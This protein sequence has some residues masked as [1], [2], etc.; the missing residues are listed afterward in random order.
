M[1]PSNKNYFHDCLPK[2]IDVTLE[3]GRIN[4]NK[5]QRI[6]NKIRLIDG[7]PPVHINSH[8]IILIRKAIE[9][10]IT[11]AAINNGLSFKN[12][13]KLVLIN[14]AGIAGL[15][16]SFELLARGFNV[17]IAEKRKSFDRFNV[18]N[19][20]V[21][22]Q[23]FLKKFGLL[24]EFEKS[25]AGRI[26]MHKY[27]LFEEKGI[28]NLG[29]SD[30]SKLLP[31]E[32]LFEPE[33]FNKL[34]NEDGIYSVRIKD[35]Q[36]FLSKKA[37]DAGVHIFGNIETE[38]LTCSHAGGVSKVKLRGIDSFSNSLEM[39]PHLLFLAEGAHSTTAK[40]LGMKNTEVKNECTGENWIFGS[41][42]YV[43]KET[44]VVSVIDT[45]G[46]SLE[47]ANII[48]N[49]Q[50]SE[51]N[52][53]VTSK[54]NLSQELM[55]QRLLKL[56]GRVC[57]H[58]NLEERQESLIALVKRPVHI[59]NEKRVIYSQD[60]VFCI[61]D[62]AG[63]SSPLAGM[64][65]TLGLT[66]VPRTIEQLVKDYEQQPDKAHYNFHRFTD[67]YTARWIAKSQAVKNYC[68][69]FFEAKGH[70]SNDQVPMP[71]KESKLVLKDRAST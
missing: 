11:A 62:A 39:Q 16:A 41:V 42:N 47:I 34:F 44:F 29:S 36:T 9:F 23:R 37:L 65:G 53:A 43:G 54:R 27:L 8:G 52:I 22:S 6:I 7:Q 51:I 66:L 60:N 25:V 32:V 57:V 30:V 12:S 31:S 4:K 35:L 64:G 48:F 40:Q 20:D 38:V 3:D 14:G 58:L 19:L 55:K 24:N 61:G 21:E 50:I 1:R 71:N 28:Q 56:V 13:K 68:L 5:I 59:I 15:A 33:Y 67:A 69:K 46:G 26:R 17:I 45:S 18:I 10:C 2:L 49:A 63:H 70:L